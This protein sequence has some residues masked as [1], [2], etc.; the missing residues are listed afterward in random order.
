MKDALSR[1]SLSKTD[2]R[3]N[4]KSLRSNV[5]RRLFY[6]PQYQRLF[7]AC[8]VALSPN[9]IWQTAYFLQEIAKLLIVS[10]TA[11]LEFCRR[12]VVIK[13][14]FLAIAHRFLM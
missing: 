2:T 3:T 9:D 12:L 1:N 8:F 13:T 7:S 10:L 6:T 11:L 5:E 14:G 4:H